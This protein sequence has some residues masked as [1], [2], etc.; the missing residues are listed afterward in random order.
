MVLSA[1]R[2]R[3]CLQYVPEHIVVINEIDDVDH[4]VLEHDAEELW[5]GA[6][7]K[8]ILGHQCVASA[9]R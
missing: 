1:S 8:T 6:F 4:Q 9:K 7:D 3:R 5:N 2:I